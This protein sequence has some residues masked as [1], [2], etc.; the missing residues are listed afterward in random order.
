MADRP[1]QDDAACLYAG[2]DE[3]FPTTP[4]TARAVIAAFCG[5]CPV[6]AQCA[7]AAR[8]A[9][10]RFGVWG[11]EWMEGSTVVRAPRP[12]KVTVPRGPTRISLVRAWAAEQ[13]WVLDPVAAV[14]L[15]VR[16]AW[17]REHQELVVHGTRATRVYWG[18]SCGP[19]EDAA[20]AYAVERR[21]R[22]RSA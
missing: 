15:E 5:H 17:V 4:S 18:C 8:D 20:A 2:P 19:C 9:R 7:D 12:V 3:M 11:G 21:Q 22:A 10:E 16:R 1:W 13:G 14:P 6:V